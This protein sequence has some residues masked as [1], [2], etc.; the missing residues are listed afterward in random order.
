MLPRLGLLENDAPSGQKASFFCLEN[1]YWRIIGLDTGY[2]SLGWP[3]IEYVVQP[4]CALRP[5]EI[6]WL[7][8]TVRPAPDDP[9]GIILLTHHQYYSR[10]DYWYPRQ[11]KQLSE[12]F[13]RP[14]L[15]FWGHEHRLAIYRQFE[16]QGGLSAF[17]RCIGHG[18]M[19]VDLPPATPKHPECAVEFVD[20][21][22]YPNDEGLTIGFNGHAQM[23]L[24]GPSATIDY[25]DLYGQIL[26][27]E[28]WRT[29][30]GS[31]ERV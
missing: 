19:P 9:R 7:R 14:V 26:F 2:D 31:L 23:V 22:H 17:G 16:V 13:H 29:T 1:A 24:R 20:E 30:N 25:L 11:A 3:L 12:F 6:A 18:G 27:S 28:E 5:E 21:R 8:Q 15:W 10:Y 4:D